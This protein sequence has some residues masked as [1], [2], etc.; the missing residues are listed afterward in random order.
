[1]IDATGVEALSEI[2]TELEGCEVEFP[3]VDAAFQAAQI[4][5]EKDMMAH[6]TH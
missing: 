1:M 3:R 6:D 2:V 5:R 4:A